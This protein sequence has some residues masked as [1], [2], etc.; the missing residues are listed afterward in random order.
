[1]VGGWGRPRDPLFYLFKIDILAHGILR[2]VGT[3]FLRLSP[4]RRCRGP[5]WA[6]LLRPLT[7]ALRSLCPTVTG[8][9]S[10]E[11]ITLAL[12]IGVLHIPELLA[13]LPGRSEN[14]QKEVKYEPVQEVKYDP[15]EKYF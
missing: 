7:R 11:R 3:G 14:G 9:K 4:V 12:H 1:M 6:I 5:V 13:H 8:V 15:Q 10:L 2:A